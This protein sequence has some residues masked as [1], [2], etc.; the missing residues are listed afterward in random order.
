MET[1][2]II[3]DTHKTLTFCVT[4]VELRDD[5]SSVG[6]WLGGCW[7]SVRCVNIFVLLCVTGIEKP[8][9]AQKHVTY[10]L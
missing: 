8:T 4:V 7:L 1:M 9:R 2:R 3:T 6:Q 5:Y 10:F